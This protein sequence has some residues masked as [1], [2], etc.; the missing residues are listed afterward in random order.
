MFA[1][2]FT[3]AVFKFWFVN[4]NKIKTDAC[5]EK[6]G[7]KTYRIISKDGLCVNQDIMKQIKQ[8]KPK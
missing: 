1:K 7:W 4:E 8:W 6:N 5:L 3:V 2:N